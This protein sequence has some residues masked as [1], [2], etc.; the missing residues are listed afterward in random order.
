[1]WEILCELYKVFLQAKKENTFSQNVLGWVGLYSRTG[2]AEFK[3]GGEVHQ[4]PGV[5]AGSWGDRMSQIEL[6]RTDGG[7]QA[8]R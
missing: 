1:M 5:K 3:L 8:Q 2:L 4:G 7:A 6:V